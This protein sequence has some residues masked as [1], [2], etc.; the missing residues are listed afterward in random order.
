MRFGKAIDA[1]LSAIIASLLLLR[2]LVASAICL[3]PVAIIAMMLFGMGNGALIVAWGFLTNLYFQGAIYS[4]ANGIVAA[5]KAIAMAA[6]PVLAALTYE[7]F[8]GTYLILFLAV[9]LIVAILLWLLRLAPENEV[10]ARQSG[11]NHQ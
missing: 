4:R 3:T 1:R 5:P 6:G 10:A 11:R 8:G 2:I 9:A 7:R